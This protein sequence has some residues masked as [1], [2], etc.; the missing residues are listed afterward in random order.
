MKKSQN[1]NIVEDTKR[2]LDLWLPMKLKYSKGIGLSVGIIYGGELI[3][4]KG[5][6]FADQE[7]KIPATDKTCY[8]IASISK[9]FTSIA[10]FQ[11]VEKGKLNIES[12]VT[13][14]LPWFKASTQ[15]TD[16][17]NITIREL[18]SHTSGIWRDGDTLHW[19][20]DTWPDLTE[21]TKSF[22]DKSLI[23]E[24]NVKFKYSNYGY[25]ILGQ[26]IEKITG[27][28]YKDYINENIFKKVGLKNTT[29]DYSETYSNI[30]LLASGYGK[31][32]PDQ[33][34]EKFKHYATKVY[35]PATGFISNVEDLTRFMGFVAQNKLVSRESLK[36]IIREYSTTVTGEYYGFGSHV[37]NVRNKKIVGHS[38]GFPGFITE[39]SF[40]E[41]TGVGVVILSNSNELPAGGIV[42]GIF[43]TVFYLIEKNELS[44]KKLIKFD[45]IY[46]N[47]WGDSALVTLGK[48]I[49]YFSPQD[50]IPLK[51]D[52]WIIQQKEN[53]FQFKCPGVYSVYDEP[54]KFE[55]DKKTKT[56]A[57]YVGPYKHKKLNV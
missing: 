31:I 30:N 24:N 32:F 10:I 56:S 12:K 9:L 53:E 25:A 6:G 38:G 45:G 5:F 34:R 26:I 51:S 49:A 2:L 41:E 29:T 23:L 11:L 42:E 36:Q 4:S 19:T 54:V 50:N 28:S 43:N 47:R 40:N 37:Y 27:K 1:K 16:A 22:S 17:K 7:K 33:E 46:R 13:D 3:Y 44:D 39:C 15:K 14:I 52:S 55:T 18:L 35:A 57:V 21:F 20:D 8:R 48:K